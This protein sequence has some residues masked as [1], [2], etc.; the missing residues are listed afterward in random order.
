VVKEVAEQGGGPLSEETAFDEKRVVEAG[1]CG[2]VMKGAGVSRFGVGGRI[3]QTGETAGVGGAG[4]HGAW[5]QGGVEGATAQAP[6]ARSGGGA[7]DREEFGVGG[8]VSG[9]LAFIGGDGQNLSSPRN[10][11]PDGYLP[12]LG[13][14]FRG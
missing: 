9:S 4:A 3:D 7:T 10:N 2:D 13:R 14:V 5:L 1:I 12:L 11:G 6:A 8:G